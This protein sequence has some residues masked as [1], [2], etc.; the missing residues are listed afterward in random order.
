MPAINPLFVLVEE[1]GTEIRFSRKF[2]WLEPFNGRDYL[3]L[4]TFAMSWETDG[5]IYRIRVPAGFI[6]DIAS[7]PRWAWT[8]SGIT[9]DGLHRNAALIHDILYMWYRKKLKKGVLPAG[10]LQIRHEGKWIDVPETLATYDK[11]EADKLFLRIMKADGV[12]KWN[13]TR[14]FLAVKIGGLPAW[15]SDNSKQQEI[16]KDSLRDVA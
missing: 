10:W 5:V 15:L 9:P 14:M 1:D 12:S 7:V 6:T 2:A 16:Y 4:E 8:L 3:L 11:D 13:R